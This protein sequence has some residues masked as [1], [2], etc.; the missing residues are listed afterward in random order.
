MS[1]AEFQKITEC[2]ATLDEQAAMKLTPVFG[3]AAEFWYRM[4]F[5]YNVFQKTGHEPPIAELPM[6]SRQ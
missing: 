6:L 1:A 4:W 5:S 3:P 2:T